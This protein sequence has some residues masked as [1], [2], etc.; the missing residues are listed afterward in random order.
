MAIKEEIYK[1]LTSSKNL[2]AKCVAKQI[3][4]SKKEVNSVLYR[5]IHL[6]QVDEQYRWSIILLEQNSNLDTSATIRTV[7]IHLFENLKASKNLITFKSIFLFFK[8]LFSKLN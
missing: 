5:N 6:F 8:S 2:K 4:C 1:V 7:P 3:G